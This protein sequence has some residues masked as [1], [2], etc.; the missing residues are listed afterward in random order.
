MKSLLQNTGTGVTVFAILVL[1]L[2][3]PG[4]AGS[5]SELSEFGLAPTSPFK[6]SVQKESLRE[7]P[8]PRK[9]VVSSRKRRNKRLA[10]MV[11]FWYAIARKK[12]S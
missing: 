11:Y 8:I 6:A 10:A 12:P 4:I 3:V 1:A 7:V 2:G 5:K 9:T